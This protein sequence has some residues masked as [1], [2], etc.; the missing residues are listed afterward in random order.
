MQFTRILVGW[1]A[2][3][4]WFL[5]AGRMLARRRGHRLVDP[6]W[7]PFA[8]A[9]PFTLLAALWFGSLGRGGW[10]LVFVLVA[11]VVELP[12]LLRSGWPPD[13]PRIA[14]ALLGVARLLIAAVLLRGVL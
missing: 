10:P 6:R 11:L 12:A 1:L 7:F 3:G 13:R 2:V 8:E 5:A 4:L 9:A 14:D